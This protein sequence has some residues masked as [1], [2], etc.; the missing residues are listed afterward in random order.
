VMT[1]DSK[2]IYATEISNRPPKTWAQTTHAIVYFLVFNLGCL[3]INA[4]QFVLLPLRF[5]PLASAKSLY[6]TGIRLSEGAFGSLLS[7]SLPRLGMWFHRA[8]SPV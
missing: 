8:Y 2:C 5:L 4:S 3:M 1:V 7:K 6:H